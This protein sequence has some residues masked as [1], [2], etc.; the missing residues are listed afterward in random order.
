MIGPKC[1]L[2]QANDPKHA[3]KVI[4]KCSLLG[5]KKN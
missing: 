1:I 4:K 3:A 2:H 5:V